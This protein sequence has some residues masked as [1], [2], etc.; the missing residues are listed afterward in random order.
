MPA[1]NLNQHCR[2]RFNEFQRFPFPLFGIARRKQ[3]N[4]SASFHRLM[5]NPPA[6]WRAWVD[7]PPTFWLWWLVRMGLARSPCPRVSFIG[8]GCSRKLRKQH[9]ESPLDAL[10]TR[11]GPLRCK[12]DALL[13]I[14]AIGVSQACKSLRVATR[15]RK[16]KTTVRSQCSSSAVPF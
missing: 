1:K 14:V 11:F 4:A 13:V 15:A 8:F 9:M 10:W 2:C 6:Q 7:A 12:Q 5:A 16:H 3:T